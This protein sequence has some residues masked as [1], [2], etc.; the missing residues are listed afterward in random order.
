MLLAGYEGQ[1]QS[2]HLGPAVLHNLERMP[3]H[4]LDL[5]AL[6]AVSAKTPEESC[7][8]VGVIKD[9]N[10]YFRNSTDLLDTNHQ[11]I[12]WTFITSVILPKTKT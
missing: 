8:Q 3:V 11:T 9:I 10:D 1:G 5:P 2:S 12:A 4:V 6:F 7:S